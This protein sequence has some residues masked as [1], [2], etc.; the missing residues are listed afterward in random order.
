MPI[1]RWKIVRT[2]RP[3]NYLRVDECVLPNGQAIQK[4]I[5]EYDPWA[6]VVAITTTSELVMI[7]QYRH[8]IAEVIWEIPAGVIEPGE[9]PHTA[10][11][12]ELL[13]ETGYKGGE[14]TKIGEVSPNPDNHTNLL[15]VFLAYEV[16]FS[17][18]ANPEPGEEIEVH[19]IPIEQAYRMAQNSELL[20][21]MQVAALFFAMPHLKALGYLQ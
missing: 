5:H 15:H 3:Y 19:L 17:G 9:D 21:S 4:L 7:R 10:A 20:Q 11:K 12:R 8:A 2:D 1:Q 6:V 14:W 13:E 16:Q 18:T